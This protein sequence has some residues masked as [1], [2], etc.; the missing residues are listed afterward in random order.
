MTLLGF[1]IEELFE[2]LLDAYRDYNKLQRMVRFKLGEN[3][4]R[5]APRG[6]L[7]TVVFSLIDSAEARGKL[8]PLII[9]AYEQNPDNQKLK[10]IFQ[11]ISV[12]NTIFRYYS[13]EICLKIN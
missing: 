6:D 13:N 11:T 3:L 5:L 12:K 10:K 2:A 9:G 7:E 1:E 4:E 8:Q